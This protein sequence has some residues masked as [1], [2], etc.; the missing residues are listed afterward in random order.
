[1]KLGTH[2]LITNN[3]WQIERY[4]KLDHFTNKNN[5]LLS[6]KTGRSNAHLH[7]HSFRCLLGSTPRLQRPPVL[8]HHWD[9]PHRSSQVRKDHPQPHGLLQ[10]VLRQHLFIFLSNFLTFFLENIIKNCCF[11]GKQ[12][13]LPPPPLYSPCGQF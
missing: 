12:Y 8:R 2:S 13:D 6:S 7:R 3:S 9:L 10:Q 5:F 11:L 1:M 4:K